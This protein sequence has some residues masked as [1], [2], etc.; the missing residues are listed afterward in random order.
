MTSGRISEFFV[1]FTFSQLRAGS[2]M[3]VLVL[4]SSAMA[5]AVKVW[6][7]PA[8]SA[9]WHGVPRCC[10]EIPEQCRV[11]NQEG[12]SHRVAAEMFWEA[13]TLDIRAGGRGRHFSACPIRVTC[14]T[15]SHPTR[16]HTRHVD[17][18]DTSTRPTRR[19]ARHVDAPHTPP[20]SPLKPCWSLVR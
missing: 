6:M 7:R 20:H 17:T 9:N 1:T 15:S 3:P 14:D 5:R 16:R 4:V 10:W 2:W 18:P 13:N 11:T 12:L 8:D 19:H